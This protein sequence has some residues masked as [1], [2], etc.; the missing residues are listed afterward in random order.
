[1]GMGITTSIGL[2]PARGRAP[3]GPATPGEGC[4]YSTQ[5]RLLYSPECV[6]EEFS[7]VRIHDLAYVR[8][9]GGIGV[10]RDSGRLLA[11][12]WIRNCLNERG[13]R[14][15]P[16]LTLDAFADAIGK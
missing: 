8:L 11:K 3:T 4:P 16:F 14:F 13:T 10:L 9:T 7:E 12:A 1:M 2:C 6:E 5:V 15:L